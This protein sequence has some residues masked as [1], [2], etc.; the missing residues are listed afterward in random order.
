MLDGASRA[1]RRPYGAEC[2]GAAYDLPRADNRSRAPNGNGIEIAPR[3]DRAPSP[4]PDSLLVLG[5]VSSTEEEAGSRVRFLFLLAA[6][7]IRQQL[8]K[9]WA[10]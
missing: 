7:L 6:L 1:G 5:A 9:N 10:E 3:S 4:S 8:A 2:I